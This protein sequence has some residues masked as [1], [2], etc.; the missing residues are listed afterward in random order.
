MVIHS[1]NSLEIPLLAGAIYPRQLLWRSAIWRT[2]KVANSTNNPV[3][4]V[5]VNVKRVQLT[6]MFL[7]LRGLRDK[8]SR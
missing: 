3:V 4:V 1:L 8:D 6:E 5:N 2:R 7:T